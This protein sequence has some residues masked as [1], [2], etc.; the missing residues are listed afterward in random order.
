MADLT[1]AYV[2]RL[3]TYGCLMESTAN[4]GLTSPEVLAQLR[5]FDT[6]TI[7]NALEI[8][9]PD[10]RGFGYTTHPFF[11]PRPELPPIVGYARTATIRAQTEP[12]VDADTLLQRRLGYYEYIDSGDGPTI[13]VIQDLDDTPGY[14]A[15]WGEVN[16]NIHQGLG[17]LGVITNGSIRDLDDSAE[18]FQLLAGKPG[19]S[20]AWVRVEA[21]GVPVV[22]HGMAVEPNDLIHADQHGAVV[23]PISVADQLAEAATDIAGREAVLISAAQ[24][25]GFDATTLRRLMS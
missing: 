21:F 22:V 2:Q 6:P 15:W 10:R 9:A 4:S 23:I 13:T 11:A 24:Q 5:T 7:C 17:S 20:H 12:T 14:G 1:G 16:T 19:P 3:I 18:G 8:V 25:P